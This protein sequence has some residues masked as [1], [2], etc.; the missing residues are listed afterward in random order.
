VNALQADAKIPQPM[1]LI[2]ERYENSVT[3][4]PKFLHR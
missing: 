4:R 2:P 3:I 1:Q